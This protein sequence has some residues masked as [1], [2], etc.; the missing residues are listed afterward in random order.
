L[1]HPTFTLAQVSGEIDELNLKC[2]AQAKPLQY[3]RDVEWTLT[4]DWTAWRL[5]VEAAPG[6][7]FALYEFD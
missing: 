4:N 6:T 5:H 1:T 2:G 7:T 3:E